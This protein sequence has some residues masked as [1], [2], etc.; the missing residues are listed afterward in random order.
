[1]AYWSVGKVLNVIDNNYSDVVFI[2]S[3]RDFSVGKQ[4]LIVSGKL[5][6]K[7]YKLYIV[8]LFLI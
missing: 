5:I 1:M 8:S 6:K 4:L 3:V 2:F 7:N